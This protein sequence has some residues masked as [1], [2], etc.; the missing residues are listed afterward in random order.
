[1]VF[2][3]FIFIRYVGV[4]LG[5]SGIVVL[6]MRF[7]VFFRVEKEVLEFKGGKVMF[8]EF[9]VYVVEVFCGKVL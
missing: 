2:G 5:R 1:M 8:V 7:V 9:R 3:F 4:L 6:G